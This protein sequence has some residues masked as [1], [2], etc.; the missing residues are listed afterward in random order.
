MGATFLLGLC[1]AQWCAFV[2]VCAVCS[3]MPC[4]VHGNQTVRRNLSS[5]CV[6]CERDCRLACDCVC[7]LK[8]TH[9]HTTV[10]F[11]QK[12]IVCVRHHFSVRFSFWSIFGLWIHFSRSIIATGQFHPNNDRFNSFIKC[13]LA[14]LDGQA[15]G[16]DLV[17]MFVF[18]HSY[19]FDEWCVCVCA[20]VFVCDCAH[21]MVSTYLRIRSESQFSSWLYL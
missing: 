2:C 18:M 9:T 8:H 1:C 21:V 6:S 5:H 19:N 20:R 16:Y 3:R 13:L 14:H 4:I 15:N 7:L 17:H 12:L 11:T 10:H